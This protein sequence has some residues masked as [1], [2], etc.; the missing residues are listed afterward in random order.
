MLE[1][2][3]YLSDAFSVILML[4]GGAFVLFLMVLFLL[5]LSG[6]IAFISNIDEDEEDANT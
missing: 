2:L 3:T 4:V 5:Y 1:L 6:H